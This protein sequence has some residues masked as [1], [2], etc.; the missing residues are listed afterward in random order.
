MKNNSTYN[1][2]RNFIS[3]HVKNLFTIHIKRVTYKQRN[4]VSLLK[5]RVPRFDLSE[6]ILRTGSEQDVF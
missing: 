3:N 6:P 2:S 4:I 1:S 5:L